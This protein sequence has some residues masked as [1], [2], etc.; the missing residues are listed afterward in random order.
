M[1][2]AFT[3]SATQ[4]AVSELL[5]PWHFQVTTVEQ[6]DVIISRADK[7]DKTSLSK[8]TVIIPSNLQSA[9]KEKR[10][11]WVPVTKN[12]SLGI[13]PHACSFDP[14]ETNPCGCLVNGSTFLLSVDI[15]AEYNRILD[16][17]FNAK[18]SLRYKLFT[19]LPIPYTLAPKH[20]RDIAMTHK[21]GN[22]N[23]DYCD[24]LPLD[25]LRFM[26]VNAIETVTKEK[27]RL[28]REV[29]RKT[30]S[31]YLV[32]HDVDTRKG[33]DRALAVK[34]VEEKYDI[35]STWFV[36]SNHYKLDSEVLTKLS[37]HGE[38]GSH[39]TE[40]DG[41]LATLKGQRLLRRIEESK[42]KLEKTASCQVNGFR[43][44]LL[45][46]NYR[47]LEGLKLAYLTY[48]SSVPTFE[49]YHP[50]TMSPH[51]IG[52]VFPIKVNGLMEIPVTI[53][54]DH[55]L[56]YAQGLK[57]KEVIE[58]WE[59]TAS[60]I[61]IIGGCCLTLSH[62]EYKLLEPENLLPLY[63]EYLNNLINEKDWEIVTPIKTI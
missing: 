49:P 12:L 24:K 5:R 54:Q 50:R 61:K 29:Q 37:S 3:D 57:P 15:V 38:I 46:H 4:I 48:D 25:A 28:K 42:Q 17:T 35:P 41:K 62:P 52:T 8:K 2:I 30:K 13:T 9:G 34:E 47:I 44:P 26:L 33:L 43:A 14:T 63:E 58:F 20:L 19:S 55:Q 11:L 18:P 7:T 36:P 39:D 53:I 27:M 10:L 16:E 45:Q 56:L 51:G 40:H 60:L 6:A 23:L 21:Q 22:T 59:S 1:Q 31:V 32:T